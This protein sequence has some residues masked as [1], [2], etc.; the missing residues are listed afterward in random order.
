MKVLTLA[1]VFPNPAQ[2][3]SGPFVFERIRHAAQHADIRVIAP[4][5][6]F[7]RVGPLTRSTAQYHLTIEHPTFFYVP[8]VLKFLDGVFLFLSI[9]PGVTRIRRTFDFDL[10]D[11][12]FAIPDGVAA[13]LL[14][15]WFRRPVVITL[16]GF[17]HQF[18]EHRL[19]RMMMRWA[20]GRATRVIAVSRPLGA[21]ALR[22]GVAAGRIEVIEN[23]VDADKYRPI[24]RVDAKRLVDIDPDTRL[25]V[26]VGHLVPLKGFH[27]IIAALPRLREEFPNLSLAIVGGSANAAYARQLHELVD[28]LGL[29]SRVI[30]PGSVPADRVVQWLNASDVLVLCSDREGCPNVVWE[31]M[32][33]GRP[34]V[35]P[36]VG[37]VEEMVPADAGILFDSPG[38]GPALVASVSL[39]LNTEWD[40]ERIRSHAEA[41]TWAHV[42]SRVIHQWRLSLNQPIAAGEPAASTRS[43]IERPYSGDRR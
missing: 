10:I 43:G 9:L 17:E 29:R 8:A 27:R 30:F 4:V 34:V 28:Q 3:M 32:A 18:V 41:H 16:R 26:C 38:D 2:P 24:P 13:T 20:L 33:C 14:G 22:L 21:L 11:A 39:A 7:R 25:L 15:Y 40:S 35:S 37:A 36:K 5:A 42:A 1:T 19:R 31:A 23:G 6:W 12:H